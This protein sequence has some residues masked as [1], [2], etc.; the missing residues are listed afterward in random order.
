LTTQQT[1][2]INIIGFGLAGANIA[3][4]L[5]KK[6]QP[7]VIYSLKENHSSR[8]A[9][10][11]VNP[12]VFKRLTKSWNADILMD[13][14]EKFYTKK[15]ETLSVKLLARKS[16]HCIFSNLQD[17]ND[18]SVKQ[19]D[20]RFQHFLEPVANK[21][22]ENV[23]MPYGCGGVVTFGPLNINL[24]LDQSLAFFENEGIKIYQKSFDYSTVLGN[25]KELFIFCEGIGIIKNPFFNYLPL[26]PT[27]GETLIIETDQLNFTDV[28]N[29]NMFVLPLG[30]NQFKIGATYNWEITEPITT[31]NGKNEL[32]KK[33]E[34]LTSC[35]YKVIDH[36]AGIRPTVNDRRPLIGTHPIYKNA[37]VFNDMGTKGV[38]ISPYYSAQ[39]ISYLLNEKLLDQ[40]VNI[41]RYR[42]L[43]KEL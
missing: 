36:Q 27:H 26:K 19:N 12:I 43:Y 7:F 2:I 10:G 42:S 35:S 11:I 34:Q 38:L 32:L 20:N 33:F 22:F 31:E 24:F 4:Q 13:Y 14:A 8:V 18:W 5:F 37:H 16:I 29:K 1:P 15:E 3:W 40:E 41:E 21:K 17:E 30:N 9:A 39:F 23:S 28:L 25:P 6:K